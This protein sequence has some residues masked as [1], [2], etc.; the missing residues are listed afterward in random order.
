MSW[1]V[2]VCDIHLLNPCDSSQDKGPW[3]LQLRRILRSQ[4]W[5]NRNKE[6]LKEKAQE[7]ARKKRRPITVSI[8][9][10]CYRNRD[11][12]A[13]RILSSSHTRLVRTTVSRCWYIS[14]LQVQVQILTGRRIHLLLD[15]DNWRRRERSSWRHHPDQQVLLFNG[16]KLMDGTVEELYIQEGAVLFLTLRNRGGWFDFCVWERVYKV[17]Y[18]PHVQLGSTV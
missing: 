18:V 6:T 15:W 5:N 16:T 8:N 9:S 10:P 3:C 14:I 7:Q 17:G 1:R 4:L 13:V 11:H 2:R 12:V